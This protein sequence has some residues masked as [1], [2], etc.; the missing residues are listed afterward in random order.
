[1]CSFF[2]FCNLPKLKFSKKGNCRQIEFYQ[3]SCQPK[4]YR[5][6]VSNDIGNDNFEKEHHYFI[7]KN[8][9]QFID[10]TIFNFFLPEI[11]IANEKDC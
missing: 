7:G 1:M 10:S 2:F 5:N 3:K 11:L 4:V 6:I 9:T 8:L